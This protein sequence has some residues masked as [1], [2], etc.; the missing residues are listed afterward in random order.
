ME[1]HMSGVS[2]QPRVLY[3]FPHKLGADRICYTAWQQ[4]AGLARAG[5]RLTVFSGAVQR[6]VPAGV[7]LHTTLAWGP[8][9]IPYRAIGSR[10]AFAWHDYFVS[11][12]LRR[13]KDRIDL[14]HTWPQGA[15]RTLECAARLGI[16][17]VLERP[18]A[19]TRFAYE[20]VRRECGRLGIVLPP[21][22]EHAFN[23]EV[24][25]LEEAE[26]RRAY[27]LLCP[28]DFVVE[29]FV[30]RG[31]ERGRLA[32]HLYGFDETLYFP[33]QE[34]DRAGP[35]RG[36][37][38]LF[39]GVCAVRK[40]L[41]FALEAWLGSPACRSG[42]FIIAGEFLPAY[43]ERL[44][45]MLMQPSVRVLGHSKDVPELMRA[46][47]VLI[48]PSIEEGF[49][50]VCTEAMACGCVPVVSEACT[51]L[52]R[53]LENALVHRVGDVSAIRQH[54]TQLNSDRTLLSRLRGA[55]LRLAPKVTWSAA[56]AKLLEVYRET[57]D[58]YARTPRSLAGTTVAAV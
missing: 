11:R 20:A 19:H 4:V 43:R 12:Q 26:F 54:L 16:P 48:L 49:G 39:V 41:H 5:T 9:R 31:F 10:R 40:G 25:R 24:L 33:S 45:H 8:L 21:A 51:E 1:L 35:E 18:N 13:M 15:L 7:E 57:I 46:S 27:R 50:L 44:A 38:V 42:T 17:A 34:R 6:A 53:H 52:C 14:V 32:R 2:S 28:S 23:A 3:S 58:E 22:H 55:C 47:D 30:D 29:T 37:V 36:L 56:G